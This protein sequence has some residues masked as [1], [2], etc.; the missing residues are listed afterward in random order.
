MQAIVLAGGMGTRLRP[1]TYTRPKPMIAVAN[2]PVIDHIVATAAR[3]GFS[4]VIVTTNYMAEVIQAYCVTDRFEIPVRCINEERPMGTAG[5]VKNV[6][7]HITG[8]FAVIQGDS[9]SE[10]D[11]AGL[12]AAHQRL[13][14]I[15]TLAVMPVEN[16]TEF[17]IVELDGNGRIMRFLEKPKPQECFSNLANT[18]FYVFEHDVLRHIPP[19]TTYDFSF[20]LFPH[21]LT[22]G[23]PM[24]G[25]Q[26]Q[27][28]WIDLGRIASYVAGNVHCLSQ[29]EGPVL[30]P[31]TS[32]SPGAVLRPPVL[33]GAGVTVEAGCEV[34]PFS[35]IGNGVRLGAGSQVKGAI[36]YDRATVAEGA[37]LEEC[38]I[39]EEARVGREVSVGR[40]AVVGRGC[41]V[42]DGAKIIEGSRVGP[43]IAVE[44]GSVVEGVL[45]PNLDKIG[46][47]Q[48]LLTGHPAFAGLRPE[49]LALCSILSEL[50]EAP[51][52][53]LAGLAKI[54]FSR[55]HSLL[56]GLEGRQ[57][58]V[59]RGEAP[60]L[61]SLLY[62]NPDR[63]ALRAA[64]H[65]SPRPSPAVGR[66]EG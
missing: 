18:G 2:R 28:Y 58:V 34:G 45:A 8:P 22:S 65:P 51:A 46:R 57:L 54:P 11:L 6:E 36:L 41:T 62:E 53:T 37:V 47:S 44:R 59:A 3:A 19:D 10:I 55:I 61:F 20:E 17:G 25:W 26:T 5:A 9:L 15:A 1:L 31:D 21:L 63:I 66:G 48:A 4:E 29:S 49:E 12:V 32:I 27:A 23:D 38:V 16:P 24:Y 40:L 35:A 13:S 30:A 52:K 33:L 43:F 56:Y 64:Q 60:K 42:G 14:G 50:G 7:A 39:A